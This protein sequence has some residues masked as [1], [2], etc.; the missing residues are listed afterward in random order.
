MEIFWEAMYIHSF[1]VIFIYVTQSDPN[2][3]LDIKDT[4]ESEDW[5][6]Y[7]LLTRAHERAGS[8]WAVLP[9]NIVESMVHYSVQYCSLRG[10]V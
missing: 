4:L 10:N 9:V 1:R 2:E 5:Q 3:L 8:F 6:T 7:Q